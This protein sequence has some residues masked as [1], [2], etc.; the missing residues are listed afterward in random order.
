MRATVLHA[1][2]DIRLDDV[3]A[4]ELLE[5]TDAIVRVVASCVCGSDLWPYR[6]INEV[7]RPVR[8]GHEFVGIVENV[9]STVSTLQ[10][11]DFVIAPFTFSDNTCA[12]CARGV[13]TS[14]VNGGFWG[15]HDKQ[16][17][18]VD[19]GQ[20]EIV[21][22]PWADGTL[23]ATPSQPSQAMLTHL[24]TLSDVFPT[25]HH[26]AVSAGVTAGSTVAVVGDGAV[27]LSA[28]MAAKRLGA[29]TIVAMSRHE[30]RQQLARQFGADEVV[31][32]R[33]KDGAKAVREILD[34]IGADFV[35]ECVGTKDSMAQA[36]QCARPGGR[37]GYVG[38][39]HDVELNVPAMFARNIGIAGGIAPVRHYIEELLPDVL[40]GTVEPG[41]VFDLALPLDQ[42]ADGYRAMDERTAIKTM[43]TI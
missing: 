18:P 17:H 28:V 25:G 34:G 27:G 1:P 31:A 16:G 30:S 21:R 20:G 9:G 11:G 42:V 19:G 12:L 41:L 36:V 13:H 6:G 4:P 24:L 5:D 37:L 23:V 3:A 26:A 2:R 7:T 35:L 22:V 29:A 15:Q 33:G 32:E 39:P 10:V 38:V 14:C 43:L 40:D 8:I